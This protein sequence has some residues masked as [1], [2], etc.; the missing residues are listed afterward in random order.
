MFYMEY[1][2]RCKNILL[3]DLQTNKKTV[4][5]CTVIPWKTVGKF[6]TQTLIKYNHFILGNFNNSCF[7]MK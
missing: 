3:R 2:V 1:F 6:S 7:N 4:I 5:Q